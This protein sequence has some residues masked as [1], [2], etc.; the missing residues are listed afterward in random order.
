MRAV[1][2]NAKVLDHFSTSGLPQASV[3]PRQCSTCGTFERSVDGLTSMSA[4]A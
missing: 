4:N 3:R 1:Y 2:T